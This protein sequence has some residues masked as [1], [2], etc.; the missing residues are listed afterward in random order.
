[1]VRNIMV[2]YDGSRSSQVAAEQAMALAEITG[3]RLHM[4]RV[5]IAP[6]LGGE[7]DT[8]EGE[9]DLVVAAM[10]PSDDDVDGDEPQDE[11]PDLD[12][13]HRLCELRHIVCEEEHLY[14][15]SPGPRLLR[16]SWLTDLLVIGRGDE[17]RRGSSDL[18]RTAE[19]LLSELVAP[20]LVCASQLLEVRSVLVP[21][22]P[23]I[24]GGRALSFAAGLCETMNASLSVLVCDP[25]R[26]K[27]GK[28]MAAAEKA[29]RAYNVEGDHAVSLTLPLEAL[30][31]VALERET[32]LIIVPGAHKRHYLL[33]WSRNEV[34]WRALEIPGAAVLAYP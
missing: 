6:D 17:P 4:I 31:T 2:G 11:A 8:G 24:S 13:I 26:Q 27:A 19:F 15:R 23:S 3:G 12:A 29:L 28:A 32:S 22:T 10:P 16:R 33:P 20:T 34:L 21:Y 14:G 5:E 7:M 1:M 18:G 9:L 30:R 25:N